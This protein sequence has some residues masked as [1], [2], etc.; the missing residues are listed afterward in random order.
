MCVCAIRLLTSNHQTSNGPKRVRQKRWTKRKWNNIRKD[1]QMISKHAH[2]SQWSQLKIV[3]IFFARCYSLSAHFEGHTYGLGA[4]V[5]CARSRSLILFPFMAVARSFHE[6]SRTRRT[7]ICSSRTIDAWIL[8]L[9]FHKCNQWWSNTRWNVIFQTQKGNWRRFWFI[10]SLSLSLLLLVLVCFVFCCILRPTGQQLK[11]TTKHV[12]GISISYIISTNLVAFAHN[13]KWRQR[14]FIDQ[15]Y[16]KWSTRKT[17]PRHTPSIF[18]MINAQTMC[19]KMNYKT[20]TTTN[21]ELTLISE[22]PTETVNICVRNVWH[23]ARLAELD[24]DFVP[25][26]YT[27]A[28]SL[29]TITTRLPFWHC[30]R[31]HTTHSRSIIVTDRIHAY[32]L[33]T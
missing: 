1:R 22:I 13:T 11:Q 8:I 3:Y 27:V 7:V 14:P 24:L 18:I 26:V 12:H 17:S 6:H 20:A 2:K 16:I 29:N 25:Y 19:E 10:L 15:R 30:F 33:H 32:S 31:S 9:D 28:P 5:V 23:S 4:F 21:V